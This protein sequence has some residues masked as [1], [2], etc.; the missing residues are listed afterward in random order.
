MSLVSGQSIQ[1]MWACIFL[2]CSCMWRP[3]AVWRIQ[4]VL[5]RIRI[6]LFMLMRIWIKIALASERKKI[7]QKLQLFCPKSYKTIF[8]SDNHQIY[9]NTDLV[10]TKEKGI[11]CG[12]GSDLVLDLDPWKMLWI[13]I[14]QNGRIFWIRIRNTALQYLTLTSG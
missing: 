6:P 10:W 5:M 1:Q 7:L 12:L 14:R 13:R 2:L 4:K 8:L 11:C 9:K 3:T